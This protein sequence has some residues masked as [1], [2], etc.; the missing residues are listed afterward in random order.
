M[1]LSADPTY[2]RAAVGNLIGSTSLAASGTSSALTF[3][4]GDSSGSPASALG[5][6]LQVYLIAGTV[7]G[8]NGL[9]ITIYKTADTTPTY[10]T[11]AYITGPTIPAA[12][13]ATTSACIDLPPGQ[14]SAVFTNLDATNG[15]HY[16]AT[17]AL[18][19]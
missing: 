12:S 10:S 7:A 1:S 9:T 4:V 16:E 8:T 18:L 13:S 3:S 17:L 5:G 15:V 19:G 2:T 6:T 14:Y 11:V